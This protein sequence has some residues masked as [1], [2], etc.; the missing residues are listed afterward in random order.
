MG[1]S[2]FLARRVSKNRKTC[3]IHG[4]VRNAGFVPASPAFMTPQQRVGVA[5]WTTQAS[6]TALKAEK[7]STVRS[8]TCAV[9]IRLLSEPA[10]T[11]RLCGRRETPAGDEISLSAKHLPSRLRAVSLETQV[12]TSL[13]DRHISQGHVRQPVWRRRIDVELVAH[14]AAGPESTA[15][16]QI[17][18][19]R[20]FQFV[21]RRPNGALRHV[22][23]R[24][25]C[26]SIP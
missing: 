5:P 17:R 1:R 25:S 22:V 15:G 24:S 14:P 23:K 16:M 9:R 26:P 4:P 19:R 12:E 6:Q 2:I 8:Q 11:T 21:A 13:S 18:S 3:A 10:S 20:I 7:S